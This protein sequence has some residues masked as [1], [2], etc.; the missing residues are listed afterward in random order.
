M[1]KKGGIL[2]HDTMMQCTM[3]CGNIIIL[4]VLLHYLFFTDSIHKRKK[5]SALRLAKQAKKGSADP[6]LRSHP[7][8]FRS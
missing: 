6:F 7:P 3:A 4:L 2:Y 1:R 8:F 5:E